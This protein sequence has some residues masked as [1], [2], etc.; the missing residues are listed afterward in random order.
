MNYLL[1]NR[2]KKSL[3]RTVLIIVLLILFF[4]LLS[5][6][7]PNLLPGKLN[8]LGKPF[9]KFRSFVVS[10][11]SVKIESLQ[12][13]ES[14]VRKNK[15]LQ[16]E[17]RETRIKLLEKNLLLQENQELKEI[18]GRTLEREV[19][20][21]RVL[22]KPPQSLYDSIIIDIGKNQSLKKGQRVYLSDFVL[23]GKIEEVY[24]NTSKVKLL[25]AP[26][27]EYEIEIGTENIPA[28]ARGLGGG[29]F[30]IRLPRGVDVEIGDEVVV[31]SLNTSLLGIVEEID[32]KAQ[33]PF[34]KILFKNPFNLSQIK[35][36]Q[37]IIN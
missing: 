24:G 29:N 13:K 8:T 2:Q 37:V 11:V 14:L 3:R 23:I 6:A 16:R 32:S 31:P 28:I 25:S 34:Q 12:S 1:Q 20:L 4:I 30:E 27:E 5:M 10:R 15:N 21:A 26:G 18:L 17:L 19:L 36:I 22:S 35:W 9:W 7:S 33:D